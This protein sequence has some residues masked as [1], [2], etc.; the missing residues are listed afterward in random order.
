MPRQVGSFSHP[1]GHFDPLLSELQEGTL[2]DFP[3][4]NECQTWYCNI[5]GCV[6]ASLHVTS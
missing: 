2:Y 4:D 3:P 6:H 1:G 5:E